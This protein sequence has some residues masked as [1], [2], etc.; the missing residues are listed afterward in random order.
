MINQLKPCPF[1]GS[2]DVEV[3]DRDC[4]LTEKAW[5]FRAHC[6]GCG[7][8]GPEHNS[9]AEAID[10][11]NTRTEAPLLEALE[12]IEKETDTRTGFMCPAAD[13]IIKSVLKI[14]RTAIAAHRGEK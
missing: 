2:D 13:Y 9:E 11:W 10:L 6:V 1:C 4:R 14:A 12:K 7:I 8:D 3:Y 5:G